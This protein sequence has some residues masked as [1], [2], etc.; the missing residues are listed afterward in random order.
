MEQQPSGHMSIRHA[1][2]ACAAA[3]ARAL[4]A[5]EGF[6][7]HAATVCLDR[8]GR[9]RDLEIVSSETMASMQLLWH[10]V[11]QLAKFHNV[12]CSCTYADAMNQCRTGRI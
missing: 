10:Y 1:G 9:G 4:E 3:D 2:A 8:I 11:L 6:V 12:C 7:A 5:Q